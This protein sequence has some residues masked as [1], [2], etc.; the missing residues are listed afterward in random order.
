MDKLPNERRYAV[1]LHDEMSV[2]GDLV[3][4]K[5]SE[6]IVGFVSPETMN[7]RKV[8]NVIYSHSDPCQPIRLQR[9]RTI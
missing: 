6:R 9:H 2:R 8:S 1:L 7:V 5:R 4:D 3:Y